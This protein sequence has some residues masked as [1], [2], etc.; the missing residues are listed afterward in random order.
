[1]AVKKIAFGSKIYLDEVELACALNQASVDMKRDNKRV[2]TIGCL[3]TI[4]GP[5]MSGAKFS[6]YS[7]WGA[8]GFE[9]TLEAKYRAGST[10]N[11]MMVIGGTAGDVCFEVVGPLSEDVHSW[12]AGD[13][14]A[15]SGAVPDGNTVARQLAL[16]VGTSITATG[17]GTGQNVGATV[18]GAICVVTYRVLSVVGSGTVTF[19][20]EESSDNG[21]VDTYAAI[22]G[23]GA[24]FTAV[25]VQRK[26]TTSATK[27]WKRIN[28]AAFSGFTS[29][30]VTI[31]V[32]MQAA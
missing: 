6:G 20:T 14:L 23:L 2:V 22:S 3:D 27:A 1:M 5:V 4:P 31:S 16:H 11:F 29:I 25:G 17:T 24:T 13:L 26:T 10:V 7:E 28:R 12:P 32:G 9:E 30:V 8:L 21:A 18:S 15:L 19:A